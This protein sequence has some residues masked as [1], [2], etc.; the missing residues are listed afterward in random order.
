MSTVCP[1]EH[2]ISALSRK[3]FS[4]ISPSI[5]RLLRVIS[6]NNWTFYNEENSE[7]PDD[8]INCLKY[9]SLHN[10]LWIGTE[11]EGL[12]MLDLNFFLLRTKK[13]KDLYQHAV[14]LSFRN[15]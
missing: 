14:P 8:K 11:T 1:R 12:V 13:N 7:L 6:N 5:L 4:S 10:I 2:R 15:L 9:D 3:S